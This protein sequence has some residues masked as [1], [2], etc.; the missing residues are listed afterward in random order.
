[1][2]IT[3]EDIGWENGKNNTPGIVQEVAYVPLA[4]IDTLPT[5]VQADPTATGSFADLVKVVGDIVLKTG[6][7]LLSIYLTDETGQISDELQGELDGK[8]FKNML[9]FLHPG[10][11]DE[12]R[13]FTAYA[14][15]S[16]FIFIVKTKEGKNYLFGSAL[17]PA[18][19]VTAPGSTGKAPADRKGRTFSFKFDAS[20][21]T[22]TF[23]GKVTIAGSGFDVL[24]G[25]FAA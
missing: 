21:P 14:K 25:E 3:L 1:M 15:N 20:Y 12:I 22:P 10:D 24:P 8:S 19:M 23:T 2:P 13:G 18:K 4:D 9:E 17:S 7:N 16:N 11:S 5:V 6:K